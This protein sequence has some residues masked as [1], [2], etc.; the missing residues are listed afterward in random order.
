MFFDTL[1]ISQFTLCKYDNLYWIGMACET[2]V[3]NRDVRAKF[4]HPLT[5]CYYHVTYEFQSKSTLYSYMNVK[6]LVV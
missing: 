5:V 2:D 4:M 3:E 6:E 1:K